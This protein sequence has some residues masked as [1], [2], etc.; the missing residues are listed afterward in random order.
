MYY[1]QHTLSYLT[2]FHH[3]GITT[4]QEEYERSFELMRATMVAEG[5]TEVTQ[6][7]SGQMVRIRDCPDKIRTNGHPKNSAI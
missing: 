3:C 7:R 4:L 1:E 6:Q 5:K 2:P